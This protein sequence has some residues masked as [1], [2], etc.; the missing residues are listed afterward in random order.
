[1]NPDMRVALSHTLRLNACASTC[2]AS[3]CLSD[4]T[5]ESARSGQEGR[6]AV[7]TT[8]CDASTVRR[9]PPYAFANV[10][11]RGANPSLWQSAI[12]VGGIGRICHPLSLFESLPTSQTAR[13]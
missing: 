6:Y 11:D 3:V 2:S 5:G 1:M 7:N 12:H 10:N 9:P 13:P 4:S 8:H